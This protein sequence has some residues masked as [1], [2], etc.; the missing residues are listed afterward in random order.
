[1]SPHLGYIFYYPP[2]LTTV[3]KAA[4]SDL[5][6]WS[7]S[8]QWRR[9]G[10]GFCQT[11]PR[12]NHQKLW[13]L[14]SFFFCFLPEEHNS[15]VKI[16]SSQ[17]TAPPVIPAGTHSNPTVTSRCPGWDPASCYLGRSWT[18]LG[19]QFSIPCFL[20]LISLGWCEA[21]FSIFKC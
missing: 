15:Y 13:K 11:F 14:T 17:I 12:E 18:E 20:V 19:V 6:I 8:L 3:V 16:N 10:S 9:T 7:L 4:C 5:V 21:T 1:M 2:H